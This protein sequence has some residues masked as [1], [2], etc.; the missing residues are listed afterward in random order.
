MLKHSSVVPM[1]MGWDASGEKKIRRRKPAVSGCTRTINY[2]FIFVSLFF[3][4]K[5]ITV[6]TIQYTLLEGVGRT[7]FIFAWVYFGIFI[8]YYFFR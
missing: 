2:S 7:S 5:G 3:C 6:L 4:E 1:Q 8:N